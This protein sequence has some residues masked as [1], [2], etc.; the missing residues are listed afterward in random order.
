MPRIKQIHGSFEAEGGTAIVPKLARS[1]PGSD[2]LSVD[3][4][5]HIVPHSAAPRPC[6]ARPLPAG[7]A[8]EASRRWL[9]QR[10]AAYVPGARLSVTVT[11]NR[12]TMI[13]V[14]RDKG[15]YRL[16]LHHMFLDAGPDIISALG[17]YVVD[18]EREASTI[19]GA[20]IDANQNKIRRTRRSRKAGLVLQPVGQQHNL[21]ELFDELN[22]RYFG[23]TIDARITWGPRP[24]PGARRKRRNSIKMG[25]YSVEDRLIRI[26]PSLDR[27]FV[28]RYFVAWIVYHEMLH[29][30]HD[31]PIVDGRRQFHTPAFLAEE[32]LFEEYERAQQWERVHL[33]RL[34]VY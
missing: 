16:R 25:S 12:Y 9:E 15:L 21:Q 7:V 23:G 29:Q 3:L 11:D 27:P 6:V 31:I 20:F 22:A 24:K 17:R 8:D 28:P 10:L 19:L 18:N 34:L 33:N 26:H 4:D 13:S 2:G 32:R 14:K 30:K 5:D 1:R